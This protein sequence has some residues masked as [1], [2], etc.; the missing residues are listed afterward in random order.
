MLDNQR[1]VLKENVNL[2]A[3]LLTENVPYLLAN[4]LK[5]G[6]ISENEREEIVRKKLLQS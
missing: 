1:T 6:V 2:L 4:Y 5:N 3:N